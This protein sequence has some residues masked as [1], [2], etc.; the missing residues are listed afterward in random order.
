MKSQFV[1]YVVQSMFY[2]NTV[3]FD[4]FKIF[5]VNIICNTIFFCVIF[6]F[7]VCRMLNDTC[8]LACMWD[9]WKCLNSQFTTN[10]CVHFIPFYLLYREL[11]WHIAVYYTQMLLLQVVLQNRFS[12]GGAKQ[13][14]FDMTRNLF[15]LFG[16]YTTKP[17][18]YFRL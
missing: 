8:I 10:I 18:N 15:P 16:E 4:N 9:V 3:C 13:L 5:E 1:H 12:E 6:R 2:F 17:Q 14:E 7:I 11:L